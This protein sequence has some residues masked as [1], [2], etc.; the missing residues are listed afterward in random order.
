MSLADLRRRLEEMRRRR[1]GATKSL[2][3]LVARQTKCAMSKIFIPDKHLDYVPES[4]LKVFLVKDK[5][6]RMQ[7]SSDWNCDDFAR[8]L[9]NN[10]RNWGLKEMNAN[11]AYALV[12]TQ[13]HALNGYAREPDGKFIFLEPQTDRRTEIHSKPVFIL[14]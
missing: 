10:V 2:K 6:D 12:W 9:Y 13:G 1:A 5:T 3:V 14:F 4:A 7:Y 11:Y 8:N